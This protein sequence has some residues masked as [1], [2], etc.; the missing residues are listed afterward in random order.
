MIR[1]PL[2]LRLAGRELRGGLRGFRVFI[3]CLVIGVGA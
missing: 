3:L 1:L 2:V